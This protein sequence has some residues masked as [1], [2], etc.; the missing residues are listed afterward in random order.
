MKLMKSIYGMRQASRIWNQ[1]FHNAV[2]QWGF[3]R[4]DCEWCI[5]RRTTTT[6]TTI[7]AV[8]VDDIVATSS[9]PQEL[10]MFRDQL[11]A[12]WEIT[13]LGEPKL[14]LGIAMSRNR[15]NH[16]IS[17]SQTVKI[18]NLVEEYGQ[19]DARTVDTPMIAG[20][21]LRRPDKSTPVPADIAKWANKTPYHPLVGSLMYLAVVTHPDIAYAVG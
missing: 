18:D 7:F 5:Y 21:Q 14:A 16:T 1:T 2:S 6:G 19:I 20:L 3:E 10:E 15:T 17:L 12:Q 9:A 4:L 13:E 8:H 11:K